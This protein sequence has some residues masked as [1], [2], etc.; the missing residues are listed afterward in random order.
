MDVGRIV[1]LMA[2]ERARSMLLPV[3]TVCSAL[4]ALLML[5]LVAF[6]QAELSASTAA[7]SSGAGVSATRQGDAV[8]LLRIT[9][10]AQVAEVR[11]GRPPVKLVSGNPGPLA[12]ASGLSI[13]G[14]APPAEPAVIVAAAVAPP[15]HANQPRAPPTA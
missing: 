6:V 7:I 4:M 11:A 5:A 3:R 1:P 8:A 13:I 15:A 12:A 2:S 14:Q 9:G 10:K